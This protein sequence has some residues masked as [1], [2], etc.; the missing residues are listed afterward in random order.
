MMNAL[1]AFKESNAWHKKYNLPLCPM[2]NNPH[3]Y[4][5][6]AYKIISLDKRVSDA[7][8]VELQR[9]F[10]TYYRA[11][12][13][14]SGLIHRWPDGSGGITSHDEI[15]GAAKIYEENAKEIMLHLTMTDGVYIN[16]PKEI[17]PGGEEVCN[18]FR[19]LW[20]KPVLMALAKFR[21]G[22]F[23][24]CQY[25]AVLIVDAISYKE[26]DEAGRLRHWLTFKEMGEYPIA[27][28]AILFWKKKMADKNLSPKKCFEKYLTQ[29]PVFREFAPDDF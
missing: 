14:T 9:D 23:L 15:I 19:I 17:A 7:D 10:R 5:A 28:A 2:F 12:R 3:I 27:G 6:Y 22:I 25:A 29:I 21:L 24:Q 11:C 26:G 18:V 8:L 13:I 1:E 16:K 4:G 20:V